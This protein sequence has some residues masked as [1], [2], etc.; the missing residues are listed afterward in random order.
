MER[1][2]IH[3]QEVLSAIS[4]GDNSEKY[5][6]IQRAT[7]RKAFLDMPQNDRNAFL[8]SLRG[9]YTPKQLLEMYQMTPQEI[10][11]YFP[12]GVDDPRYQISE[13]KHP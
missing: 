9:T 2:P 6:T 10:D 11:Y 3:V 12:H 4:S 1:S 5:E 13:E 7:V 8:Y